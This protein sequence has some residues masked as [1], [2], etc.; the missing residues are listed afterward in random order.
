MT[1]IEASQ[2]VDRH[3]SRQSQSSSSHSVLIYVN[4]LQHFRFF[5]MQRAGG[6]GGNFYTG[7]NKI[8]TVP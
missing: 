4:D 1:L 6:D 2:S 8:Y 5:V 3:L 7:A